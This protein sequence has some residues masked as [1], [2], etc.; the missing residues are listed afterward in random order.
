MFFH[1]KADYRKIVFAWLPLAVAITVLCALI[2]LTVQ[3]NY[4]Q[5]ANDP[6]IQLSQDAAAQLAGGA[7]P[8]TVIGSDTVNI[9]QSLAPYIML[10]SDNGTIEASSAVLPGGLPKLPLGVLQAAHTKAFNAITWQPE[11][12]VR[13]AIVVTH[14]SG[15]QAG[16]VVAGRSLREVEKRESML[17][18][19]VLLGWV[20]ALGLSLGTAWAVKSR[21]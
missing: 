2:H 9:S 7:S 17:E 1:R 13:S 3:Q 8:G 16:Y 11:P 15:A 12:G 4:R 10:Y 14:F 5:S 20:V 6:Q 19:E 18:I 21:H